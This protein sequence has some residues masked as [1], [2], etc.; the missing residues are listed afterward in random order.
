[1]KRVLW[2]FCMSFLLL[3]FCQAGN[4]SD[5]PK[6]NEYGGKTVVFNFSNDEKSPST[7]IKILIY[8]DSNER[9]VKREAYYTEKFA[10]TEGFNK[11]VDYF[12]ANGEQI[13][14]ELYKSGVLIK[15]SSQ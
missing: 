11:M 2:T 12:G 5:V 1:M 7:V 3:G 8:L 13:K 14:K 9:K 10:D 6:K 15:S 4:E